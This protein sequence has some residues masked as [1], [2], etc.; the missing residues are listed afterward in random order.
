M[1]AFLQD[2]PTLT[3]RDRTSELLDLAGKAVARGDL[4]TFRSVV[5]LLSGRVAPR[6]ALLADSAVRFLEEG[7]ELLAR[8]VWVHYAEAALTDADSSQPRF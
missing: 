1:N 7:D 4:T 3:D 2:H 6:L 5:Q 8:Q